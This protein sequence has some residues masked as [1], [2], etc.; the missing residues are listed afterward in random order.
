VAWHA[1]T[2][3]VIGLVVGIPL[4]LVVGRI[5]WRVVADELGISPDPTWPVLGV[6]LLIP[7]VL[8]AV[9]LVGAVPAG[10]AART[11]P[12]VVLRSE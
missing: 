8:V 10:R 3:A 1:T 4:G 9:N 11:R 12:A 6:V 2:I 7:A 5:A